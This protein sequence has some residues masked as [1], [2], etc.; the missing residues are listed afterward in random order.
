MNSCRYVIKKHPSRKLTFQMLLLC[1]LTLGCFIVQAQTNQSA[2]PQ[3]SPTA[4]P[5]QASSTATPSQATQ[6]RVPLPDLPIPLHSGSTFDLNSPELKTPDNITF[7]L[8]Q[9]LSIAS[10]TASVDQPSQ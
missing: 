4:T 3:A 1:L 7:F 8:P 5:S 10:T 9:N 2:S 6:T